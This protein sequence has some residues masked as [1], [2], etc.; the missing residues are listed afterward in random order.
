MPSFFAIIE[1]GGIMLNNIKLGVDLITS[2]SNSTIV[3]I[4]KLHEKKYR[5][6]DRMF[7]CDGLKLF[8][9]ACEFCK[10]IEYII[11]NNDIEFDDK[12]IKKIQN[13]MLNG[14]IVLCV[15]NEVFSK[16]SKENSPQGI[17][18]IINHLEEI[19]N[20]STTSDDF[21]TNGKILVIESVRD[22]G[23]IG[24]IIRNSAAFGIDKLVLTS[25][26][27]DIYSS[28]VIR[29]SMGAIFKVKIDVV[30]NITQTISN[31]KSIGK[32]I[33]CAGLT[34]N[35]LILGKDKISSTDVIV[36]GN[37]GHGVSKELTLLC[38]QII[39][40]P[41]KSNTESLNAAIAASIFMWEMY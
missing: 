21:D 22:P 32:R 1:G 25:D 14:T 23:N 6:I 11:L 17:I 27:A 26:C 5:N 34:N 24:T 15:T 9:E 4:T 16:I 28:K 7:I 18:T 13:L 19:H 31:L 37:E 12:V 35:S 33:L 20:F 41:M 3:K 8:F 39:T 40:I 29:A 38:D 10:K 30:E 36:I 2:K